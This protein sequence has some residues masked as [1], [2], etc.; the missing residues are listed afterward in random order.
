MSVQNFPLLAGEGE[1]A[2]LQALNGCQGE[3]SL[4]LILV[5][6]SRNKLINLYHLKN[7]DMSEYSPLHFQ[8]GGRGWSKFGA[9]RP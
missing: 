8:G 4:D 6:C 5:P 7:R 3:V 9:S 1:T 2:S